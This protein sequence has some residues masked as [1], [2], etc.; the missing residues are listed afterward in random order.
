M[1]QFPSISE[2]ILNSYGLYDSKGNSIMANR[3][4]FSIFDTKGNVVGFSGRSIDPENPAKYL[5]TPETMFFK[6]RGIL[7]NYHE[8]KKYG[9]VYVVE[10]YCDALSLISLGIPNV[11]AAMGTSF[12]QDHIN[13]L[14]D[15]SIILSLDNDKAGKE[16]MYN[17]IQSNKSTPFKVLLWEGAKDFNDLLLKDT[18]AFADLFSKPKVVSAPEY[19]IKYLKDTLDLT[20]LS[21]RDKMWVEVASLI[22]AND[23]RYLNK[24]PINTIYT[25]VSYDYYWTIVKRIIKGK[26]G[27]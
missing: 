17:L 20:I 27:I 13:I 8:A 14:N 1:K 19:A 6:K 24:Y 7:Y 23:K 12:T 5:N 26:R 2:P 18:K 16:Q 10:G 21:D 11:V 25:P 3:Y 9:Q 22:G 15:K 4:V